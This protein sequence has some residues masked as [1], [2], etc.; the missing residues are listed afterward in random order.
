MRWSFKVAKIKGISVRLH[1]TF[2][3]FLLLLAFSATL[4]G[5]LT[6]GLSRT[7]FI[8]AVFITIILHEL[9]HS[10]VAM[11]YGIRVRDINLLPIGGIARI[12]KIPEE[13]TQELK[14]ALAGPLVSFT[15]AGLIFLLLEFIGDFLADPIALFLQRL[16]Q[17]NIVLAI[18]NL[19]PALPMDG[20]RVFR[21]LLARRMNFV[22][23][24]RIAGTVGQGLAVLLA[25]AGV[26]FNPWLLFI[27]LLVYMG[28]EEEARMVQLRSLLKDIP[29]SQAMSTDIHILSPEDTIA[30]VIDLIYHGCQQDFP[31]V[32]E[33]KVV[34]ILTKMQILSGLR[35]GNTNLTID[36]IM[37]KNFVTLRPDDLL[38]YA[39]TQLLSCECSSLPVV[40]KGE[41]K[42]ILTLENIGHYFMFES[43]LR[44]K[45]K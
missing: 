36:K 32:K 15:I 29:V 22:E 45:S 38:G 41:L 33:G 14:M 5:G 4:A 25:L 35:G 12:E 16:M 39:Y 42:G 18:F 31:V 28:A 21:A 7:A 37:Q 8:L 19:L 44:E 20:G 6:A 27:A 2:L 30:Q 1:I 40:E 10:L 24:T 9:G 17:V 23:A 26:I 34:G 3:L 13:P 43:A 11:K